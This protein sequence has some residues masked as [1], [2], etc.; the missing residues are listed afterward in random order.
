MS[1]V[2]EKEVEKQPLYRS[3][4]DLIAALVEIDQL[5]ETVIIDRVS[6]DWLAERVS[7]DLRTWVRVDGK[8]YAAF[9]VYLPDYAQPLTIAAPATNLKPGVVNLS[10]E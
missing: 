1:A 7:H 3:L 5:K 4:D 8:A 6:W 9:R 2:A 10:G